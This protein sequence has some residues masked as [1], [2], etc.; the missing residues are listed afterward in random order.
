MSEPIHPLLKRSFAVAAILL[1]A[2]A[3]L[4][5]IVLLRYLPGDEGGL[6]ESF[7]YDLVA[8]KK[9]DPSLIVADE[10]DG[11]L[12]GVQ[13]PSV[14]VSGPSNALYVGGAGEMAILDLEGI[15]RSLLK[16]SGLVTALAVESGGGRIF[17][18]FR[19]RVEIIGPSG[20]TVGGW[21]GLN[22]N[23]VFTSIV[24]LEKAV[25]VADAGNR[26]VLKYG[27]DGALI[28][29]F[30]DKASDYSEGFVIPSP[31]FPL[32]VAP[33]DTLWVV[34]T[35][36]HRFVNVTKDGRVRSMWEKSAM[37]VD[38]FCGC[39]NPTHFAVRDDGS[40]VTAEKGIV[41][42]KVHSADGSLAGVVAA[43]EKFGADTRGLSIV[44]DERGRVLVLDP[45]RG[46]V[47]IFR[48]RN[49][50]RGTAEGGT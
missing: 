12:A 42:V 41:R 23:S 14:M 6:G 26:L 25:F 9:V 45:E 39:C 31:Y 30:G 8:L 40:F 27:T 20:D 19:D 33:D 16:V 46:R 49:T 47:R 48:M 18:A 15:R 3:V 35:G 50:D 44:V 29:K 34:D 32:A 1:T 21:Q 11:F 17:A 10:V 36:R 28:S 4:C 5:L 37:T 13:H 43:P 38:G 22:S 7:R 24:L 2:A